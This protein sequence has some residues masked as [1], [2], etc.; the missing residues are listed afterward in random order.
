M[1]PDAILGTGRSDYPNQVN[2]VLCFPVHL[3]RRARRRRHHHQR[4]DEARRGARHRRAGPC[5]D[6]RKSWPRPTARRACASARDYLIPKPFDPRLIEVV[7]PAVAQAAMDSGRGHAPDR[8]HRGLPPA[9]ERSSSTSSGSGDAAGVRGGQSGSAPSGWSMPKAKTSACCAPR[10]WSSTKAWRG[11]SWSGRPAVI[12][13]AHR[14]ST[15][16]AWRQAA[17]SNASTRIDPT[18]TARRRRL[19]PAHAAPRRV[20]RAGADRDAQPQHAAGRD[21]GAAGQG[22]RHAVRHVSAA[23]PTTSTTCAT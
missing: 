1:R 20:A 5:R 13:A 7:A 18:S 4:G 23:S 15:A 22:R 2:N 12:A 16:C 8:R 19:L 11:R 10:R 6:S 3:P 9:A 21:A 14:A 17:T